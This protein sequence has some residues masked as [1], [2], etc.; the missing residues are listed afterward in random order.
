MKE[1]YGD[2]SDAARVK[3]RSRATEERETVVSDDDIVRRKVNHTEDITIE[4]TMGKD[5]NGDDG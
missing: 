5:N 3:K 2:R 1:T 4:M